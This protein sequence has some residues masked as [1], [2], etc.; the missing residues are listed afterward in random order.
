M[1]ELAR[2]H[3]AELL[4]ADRMFASLSARTEP[5]R[6]SEDGVHPT[7]AGHSALAEAWSS[8]VR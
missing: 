8:L 7:A 2:A 4:T 5:E 6:W 3:G 1:H